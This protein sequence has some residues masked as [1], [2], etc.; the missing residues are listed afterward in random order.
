[1]HI[2]R[3]TCVSCYSCWN[4]ITVAWENSRRSFPPFS[5]N[6]FPELIPILL[7]GRGG[8]LKCTFYFY[9]PRD[10]CTCKAQVHKHLFLL[11]MSVPSSLARFDL[12]T[13]C[14]QGGFHLLGLNAHW[15]LHRELKPQITWRKTSSSSLYTTYPMHAYLIPKQAT[16]QTIKVDVA[17]ILLSQSPEMAK[18]LLHLSNAGTGTV[19]QGLRLGQESSGES[20][21]LRLGLGAGSLCVCL[22]LYTLLAI[23]LN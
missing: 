14:L 9:S 23:S 2:Y 11:F 13:P 20:L 19:W 4:S 5:K 15:A 17:R 7:S 10:I 1:M 8:F 12:D 21:Q 6:L 22:V 18:V 16:Q 3:C